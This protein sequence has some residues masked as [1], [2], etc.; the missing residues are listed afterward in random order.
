MAFVGQVAAKAQGIVKG[1][2]RRYMEEIS[3]RFVVSL[4]KDEISDAVIEFEAM[5]STI[6]RCQHALLQVVGVGHEYQAAERVG[7]DIRQVISCLDDMLC[8]LLVGK[9]ELLDMYSKGQLIYQSLP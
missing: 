8:H 9:S 4:R 7:Q 6:Q 3:Q 2:T 5:Q 1:S